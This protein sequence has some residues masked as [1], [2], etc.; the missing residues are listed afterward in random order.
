[1]DGETIDFLANAM[2]VKDEVSAITKKA[3]EGELDF[4]ESL[5]KRVE[6]LK[7]L[8]YE[9]AKKIC[10]NLPFIKGA[11]E[12]IKELKNQHIKVVVF[13]GGFNLATSYAQNILGYD[14]NFANELHA[15]DG[16][17]SGL[18]GGEMMFS[19]SKGAMLKK[20][21]KLLDISKDETMSVGDGANDISMFEHSRTKVAFCA[22]SILEQN[23]N[24]IIKTK[25]LTQI[26]DHIKGE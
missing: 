15:K 26:L 18:V 23:A 6:Y 10:Q 25:D 4:F 19:H 20:L 14:A 17:L 21:Q 2:H 24:I 11:K 1:M 13:S 3:M 9:Q 5:T 8:K 7:G 12:T 16:V 22:K